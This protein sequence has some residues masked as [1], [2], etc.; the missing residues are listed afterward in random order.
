MEKK[1]LTTIELSKRWKTPVKTLESWR[2]TNFSKIKGP[3][4]L[5]IGRRVLYDLDTIEAYER[6]QVVESKI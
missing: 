3:S 5:H 4:F 6:E 2:T 1:F